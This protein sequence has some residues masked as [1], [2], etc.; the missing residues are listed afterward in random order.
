MSDTEISSALVRLPHHEA[1]PA[2][3]AP[4]NAASQANDAPTSNSLSS[5]PPAPLLNLSRI[6]HLP[7]DITLFKGTVHNQYTHPKIQTWIHDLERYF[8]REGITGDTTKIREAR[9]FVHQTEGGAREVF[10]HNPC[11]RQETDWTQF[12]ADCFMLFRETRLC[13]PLPTLVTLIKLK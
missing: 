12:R 4:Q 10:E 7:N 2:P 8:D 11:L 3:S 6:T 1:S 13:Q 5:V 9:R